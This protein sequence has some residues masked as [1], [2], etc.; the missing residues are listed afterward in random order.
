M[1]SSGTP[2]GRGTFAPATIAA[3]F[4]RIGGWPGWSARAACNGHPGMPGWPAAWR[5][6]WAGAISPNSASTSAPGTLK[7]SG[8]SWRLLRSG[9]ASGL[10]PRNAPSVCSATRAWHVS[11]RHG[12]YC[13]TASSRSWM[14]AATGVTPRGPRRG[15]GPCPGIIGERYDGRAAMIG[16]QFS[17]YPALR[18]A[19]DV[20]SGWR[21]VPI[22]LYLRELR[23]AGPA[24]SRRPA[25]APSPPQTPRPP[26]P[27]ARPGSRSVC[28]PRPA[29]R[30]MLHRP[31]GP[32][33]RPGQACLGGSPPGMGLC[34]GGHLCVLF[35]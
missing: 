14:K 9:P 15:S 17:T 27:P 13:W 22:Q 1:P 20:P 16:Q 28:P 33:K 25:G 35:T 32:R 11:S 26:R 18:A 4:V 34:P 31:P 12:N 7:S 23:G 6:G 24:R 10:R 29:G 5:T 3:A 30:R 8:G 19:L 2:G 21:L